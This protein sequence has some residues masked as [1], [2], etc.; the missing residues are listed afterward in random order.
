MFKNLTAEEQEKFA[1]ELIAVDID[2]DL[3]SLGPSKGLRK[4]LRTPIEKVNN[5]N[6]IVE[7]SVFWA[8]R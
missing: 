2:F 6:S 7:D 3:D 4:S 5:Y 8:S 1:Q